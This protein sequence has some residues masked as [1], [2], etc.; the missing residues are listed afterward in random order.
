VISDRTAMACAWAGLVMA[1]APWKPV[2]DAGV[3][4]LGLIFVLV[5]ADICVNLW[6]IRQRR[7][8]ER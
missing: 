4:L 2:S 6:R 1:L 3:S 7:R 8:R 5:V